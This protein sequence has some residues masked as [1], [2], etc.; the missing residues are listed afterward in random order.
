MAWCLGNIPLNCNAHGSTPCRGPSLHGIPL[1]LP[2]FPVSVYPDSQNK[3]KNDKK[4]SLKKNTNSPKGMQ[5]CQ[6]EQ[7]K[8][9]SLN[10]QWFFFPCLIQNFFFAQTCYI[11]PCPNTFLCQTT[12]Y[13]A[14]GC[15]TWAAGPS[16]VLL[17]RRK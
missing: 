11:T 16:A 8:L 7:V 12:L 1:S 17:K 4:K 6:Q 15:N 2:T 10:M 9:F 14:C 3:G 5:T 13:V